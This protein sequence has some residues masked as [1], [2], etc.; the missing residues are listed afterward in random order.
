LSLENIAAYKTFSPAKN[1]A[2]PDL[3][4]FLL[5]PFFMLELLLLY[6]VDKFHLHSDL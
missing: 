2:N 4:K 6:I 1:V 5:C 3:A